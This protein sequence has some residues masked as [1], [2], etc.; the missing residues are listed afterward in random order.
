[1]NSSLQPGRCGR[2]WWVGVRP[3]WLLYLLWMVFM[4][5]RPEYLAAQA[6]CG[7]SS[8]TDFGVVPPHAQATLTSLLSFQQGFGSFDTSGDFTAARTLSDRNVTLRLGGGVRLPFNR[9]QIHGGIPVSLQQR[10]TAEDSKLAA[11]LGDISAV[12]RLSALIPVLDGLQLDRP[13]SFIPLWDIYSGVKAPTA[14]GP[15]ADRDPSQVDVRGNGVF[16]W[17][18]G[19]KVT[20]SLTLSHLIAF[21]IQYDVRLS[22]E[23]DQGA[24]TRIDFKPGNQLGLRLEWL[25]THTL[26]WT[27][28]AFA[29][30]R[31]SGNSQIDG[32]EVP[33][34]E[35]R[36]VNV[37]G[38][39][40]YAFAYPDWDVTIGLNTDAFW[41]QGGVNVP[42]AAFSAT[43]A[44][45]RTFVSSEH[46][47]HDHG[48]HGH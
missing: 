9:L 41:N 33:S 25:H 16:E 26:F 4:L 21:N 44:F 31:A 15:G 5:L 37:G 45:R 46:A 11:G 22:T 42:F 14:P 29:N 12:L 10:G 39:V 47:G 18:L 35:E 40:T 7:A 13:E 8:T 17:T 20:K 32:R 48:H 23:R 28:A 34:S 3:L 6:C 30:L 2:T 38:L 43:V 36:L 24:D 27:F 1:M 19:T